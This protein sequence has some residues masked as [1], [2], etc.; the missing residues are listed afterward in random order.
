MNNK[1]SQSE[2]VFKPFTSG[3]EPISISEGSHVER[4]TETNTAG[5]TSTS[6]NTIVFYITVTLIS[7]FV[8]FALCY[9]VSILIKFMC[10][11]RVS[12]ES[13]SA[14]NF[15]ETGNSLYECVEFP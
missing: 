2:E 12:K 7:V 5:S 15:N 10:S 3:Y 6:S 11:R 4:T 1:F 8:I 14:F 9:G 13:Q